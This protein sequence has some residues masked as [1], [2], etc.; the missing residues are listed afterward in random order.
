[1]TIT[2]KLLA[3]LKKAQT[4]LEYCGY[5]DTYEKECAMAEKLPEQIADVI[6]E[7]EEYAK[8]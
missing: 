1:M 6:K 7:A 8:Q 4:H 2:Q 5:G 3:V